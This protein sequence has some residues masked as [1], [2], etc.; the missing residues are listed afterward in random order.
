MKTVNEAARDIR[1]FNETD[2]VVVG[3]GPAGVAAAVAAARNGAKTTL[4]ERYGHLGGMATGGLVILIPFMSDGT[5]ER[6][7]AGLCQE[8]IDK[9]DVVE[10]VV[11]PKDEEVGSTDQ[12][13]INYWRRRGTGAFVVGGSVRY[14]AVVDPEMLKCVLNDMVTEAGVKLVLHSWGS[15]AIT[16]DE[17]VKGMIFESKSGRQAILSKIT[18]DTTGDGDM[19]ASAGA[20][21]DGTIDRSMRSSNLALVF[22]IEDVDCDKYVEFRDKEKEAH[23]RLMKELTDKGGFNTYWRSAHDDVLWCNNWIPNLNALSVEDLTWVE[24]NARK[25]MLLSQKFLKAN[26]PGFEKSRIMDTA[27]QIGTR[28]S[29]RLMGEHVVTWDDV[30]SGVVHDDSIAVLPHLGQT[31]S[32]GFPHVYIPYRA[33]VPRRLDNLLVAGRCFSSDI[34]ANNSLNWIQQCIPMGQA[35]GTAAALALSEG[36]TPRNIDHT[37]LQ[38]SLLAQGVPLPGV[39]MESRH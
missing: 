3:G 31:V 5:A 36:V 35:A 20:E 14:G 12:K 26:V 32:K 22:R 23:D 7:I 6:Q 16:E 17:Q 27:S 33:L 25:S 4:V 11:H 37:A 39:K 29:R 1:V 10:G 24:V 28:A 21:F 2:I 8:M 18:I 9:L 34:A 15:C 38:S 30:L 13:I 19:F